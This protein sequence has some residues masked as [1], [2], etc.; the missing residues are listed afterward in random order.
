MTNHN[1]WYTNLRVNRD[2]L[3]NCMSSISTLPEKDNQLLFKISKPIRSSY[4][5]RELTLF[6]SLWWT[7]AD[8][9]KCKKLK[10]IWMTMVTLVWELSCF[11]RRKS[12]KKNINFG[13]S[14]ITRHV[15]LLKTEK[16]ECQKFK[17]CL[18]KIWF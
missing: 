15:Q 1:T 3:S 14:N 17:P 13:Q 4:T 6:C 5:L 2:K 10:R 18:K 16:K 12:L 7:K 8:L 9:L 11:V